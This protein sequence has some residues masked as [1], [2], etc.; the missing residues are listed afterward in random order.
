MTHTV[1]TTALT[2]ETVRHLLNRL[3]YNTIIDT[4]RWCC[5]EMKRI[6]AK[7]YSHFLFNS[8]DVLSAELACVLCSYS[9]GRH[10]DQFSW[11]RLCS[12]PWTYRIVFTVKS[13]V[14]DFNR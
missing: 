1:G 6:W 2:P 4:W 12:A 11:C 5:I 13:C 14:Q 8:Q 9:S 7:E 10:L 3:N